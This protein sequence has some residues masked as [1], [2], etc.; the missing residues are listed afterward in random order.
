MTVREVRLED[1]AAISEIY[2]PYV[3]DTDITYETVPPT[4]EQFAERIKKTTERYPYVVCEDE[5]EVI[6]YAYASRAGERAAYE[7]SVSMSVYVRQ[8][9]RR[10]GAARA[11]YAFLLDELVKRG[12]HTAVALLSL[13]NDASEAFHESFGFEKVGVFREMGWKHGAFHDQLLMQKMLRP[14]K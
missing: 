11:M 9:K 13:P 2:R 6:G 10:L 12:Y 5:G 7:Y 3:L 14:T 1:A 4:P 8:D